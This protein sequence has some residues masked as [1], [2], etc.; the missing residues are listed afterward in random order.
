[1]DDEK[2]A[3][4]T[5]A[6]RGIG[7]AIALEFA[8]RRYRVVLV[9]RDSPE[10]V[11][12][13]HA[14]RELGAGVTTIPTDLSVDEAVFELCRRVEMELGPVS[15]LVHS[16]GI[17]E[18]FSI[19]LSSIHDFDRVFRINARAALLLTQQLLP[20][21]IAA[22]GQVIFVSS[23]VARAPARAMQS[24]YAAS[25]YALQA[26]ADSLRAEVNDLGV[27]VIT[28]YPGRTAT[29]MQQA[30]TSAEGKPYAPELLL[31]PADIALTLCQLLELPSTAEITELCIRPMRRAP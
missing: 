16:A 23:S 25:K 12:T 9:A 28:V 17:L 26:I 18:Q 7:R 19:A 20:Q 21:L 8:R 22:S 5:G 2:T 3:L 14:I 11:A 10:L 30:L 1:M 13:E 31:Q 29:E 27:R 6:S 24:A 4:V 15:V